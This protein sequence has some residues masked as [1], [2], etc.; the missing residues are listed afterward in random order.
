MK[1]AI[2]GA[3]FSGTMTIY[4]L[5][6]NSK[7]PLQI[8]VFDDKKYLS[9]GIAY[10]PYSKAHLLNVTA[11]KMSAIPAEPDH[12]VNWV[13]TQGPYSKLDK[14]IVGNSFLPRH[15]YGLYLEHIW[16]QTVK[17]ADEK[18]ISLRFIQ[19]YV[20]ELNVNG[21][22]IALTLNNG[23]RLT[24]DKCVIA[25]GNHTP[26][27]PRI[28]NQQF[29]S[30]KKYFQNPW[31]HAS[32]TDTHSDHPILI[33]G[34]GL[35]MVD[36]V[37]GLLANGFANSIY[38]ISPNGFNT[39]PHRH[40]GIVY[41]NLVDELSSNASLREIV[42]LFN[43]HI[44]QLREFGISAEP[45]IDSIRPLTQQIWQRLS[46]REKKIFMSRLRHLWGVA[47]HRLPL[48]IYHKMQQLRLE[49]RLHI[50]AGE[51]VDLKEEGEL[52]IVSFFNKKRK[53]L[54]HLSVSRVINCTGPETDLSRIEGF[55]Q[56]CV[57]S[58]IISQDELKLGINADPTSFAVIDQS[59]NMVENLFTTGTNLKGLLWESTA[60]PEI[61]KQAEQLAGVLLMQMET[62]DLDIN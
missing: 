30:S 7:G 29:F 15:L 49:K 34:N 52:V 56:G 11:F 60:V 8:T 37:L 10:S 47:R 6:T 19:G 54:E 53:T 36:S 9:R 62:N 13:I 61:R 25:T 12:F 59:G 1:I 4:H 44:K 5:I 27:N 58:G 32:V 50:Y 24:F 35:T 43:K 51:I 18:N 2:I 20:N 48:H 26:R 31:N 16:N 23:D 22:Q 42:R 33:I 45:V 57:K 55:L 17:M 41:S 14:S 40:S 38:S 46:V 39:L 28:K 21:D 3:G